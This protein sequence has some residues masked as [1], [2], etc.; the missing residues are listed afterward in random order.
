MPEQTLYTPQA[1]INTAKIKGYTPLPESLL[2]QIQTPVGLGRTSP[3]RLAELMKLPDAQGNYA[4]R[5]NPTTQSSLTQ[6]EIRAVLATATVQTHRRSR[7]QRGGLNTQ[8]QQP[9]TTSE[10][11]PPAPLAEPVPE[12]I[13]R[14]MEGLNDQERALAMHKFRNIKGQKD[15]VDNIDTMLAELKRIRRL[16]QVPVTPAPTPTTATP[17]V[18]PAAPAPP[19][20][21]QPP[22]EAPSAPPQQAIV[23]R[24]IFRVVP[25]STPRQSPGDELMD[26]D[27]SQIPRG[28]YG[29]IMFISPNLE[30]NPQ[31]RLL[32]E[33]ES[34]LY[35][36]RQP[37]EYVEEIQQ[38]SEQITD[39]V[40]E[41]LK[42]IVCIPVAGHQEGNNIYET[43][44]N[45]IN[46]DATQDEYEVL[47]FVNWPAQDKDGNPLNA[48]ATFSAI[49]K[50]RSE[51]PDFPLRVIS[52]SFAQS[53]NIG[54]FRKYLTDVALWRTQQRTNKS[55][56]VIFI[57]N[58]ADQKGVAPTYINNFIEKF[59]ETPDVDGYLGQL[60]WNPEDYVKY[61]ALHIG[62]RLFQYLN[63]IGR[64]RSGG[65]PTSGANFA[66]KGSIYAAVGG[67]Q[68]DKVTGEDI[69]LGQAI[70]GLRKDKAR[71]KFAGARNSRLFTSTRRAIKRFIDDGL[72]P[73]EQWDDK[74]G[75]FDEA[76][77]FEQSTA[78][79]INYD[80][81]A[82]ID[83]LKQEI[84]YVIDR[85]L[86]VY[87]QGDKLGKSAPFYRKA[88]GWLGIHY[89]V[90]EGKV[91]ITDMSTLLD[92]LREYKA[93]GPLLQKVKSGKATEEEIAQFHE[94]DQTLSVIPRE[95]QRQEEDV[96]RTEMTKL[97]PMLRQ[98]QL[99]DKPPVSQ[100]LLD[101]PDQE[102][103]AMTEIDGYFGRQ[104]EEYRNQLSELN[105]QI[106]EPMGGQTKIA[107]LIPV[108]G[109][110]EEKNIYHTLESFSKQTIG[111]EN[112]EVILFVNAS[113]RRLVDRAENIRNTLKEIER[114][115][116][117][118]PHLK[119]RMASAALPDS[120]VRIG[121]IRKILTDLALLRQK[122]A[123]I[124]EDLLLLSND[125]DNEGIADNY[126]ESF[127]SYFKNNPNK[128]GAVGN[129]HFDPKGFIRFPGLHLRTEFVTKLDQVGFKNGNV[130]L[131]GS[132]SVMKSSTYAAIGGYPTN[133]RSG[134]QE[135][136]GKT[137]RDLR[138]TNQTLGYVDEAL[139]T[140]SIRRGI[141]SYISS[142]EGQIAFG[143]ITKEQTMRSLD[144]SSFPVFKFTDENIATLKT[145]IEH[146]IDEII[147]AYDQG[148]KLGK[149]SWFYSKTLQEMG[150]AYEVDGDPMN[151][152]SKIRVTDITAFIRRSQKIRE[153]IESGETNM[154]DVIKIANETPTEPGKVIAAEQTPMPE[155][156]VEEFLKAIVK[157]N[158]YGKLPSGSQIDGKEIRFRGTDFHDH[159]PDSNIERLQSEMNV[160]GLI[161]EIYK[162]QIPDL[163]SSH[164]V[165]VV[166]SED[167]PGN[168]LLFIDFFQDKN[169]I[170]SRTYNT[171][172]QVGV[173]MP[174]EVMSDFLKRIVENPDLLE[175][176]Y[177][178][179]FAGLDSQEG[180][181]GMLRIKSDG[182][183]IITGDKL[184]EAEKISKQFG[185]S[186]IT[187][188]FN[189]LEKYQ[190]KHGPYGTGTALPLESQE[191]LAPAAIPVPEPLPQVK[192]EDLPYSDLQLLANRPLFDQLREGLSVDPKRQ[193]PLDEGI[194]GQFLPQVIRQVLQTPE[195][196]KY[197]DDLAPFTPTISFRDNSVT[198]EAT[199]T[200]NLTRPY[201]TLSFGKEKPIHIRGRIIMHNGVP[202]ISIESLDVEKLRALSGPF[203]SE[204]D[205]IITNTRAK[206][207]NELIVQALQSNRIPV[208]NSRLNISG[209]AATL[210]LEN[211]PV[212]NA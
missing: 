72:A 22:A 180:K 98:V 70:I 141:V 10:P 35:F 66:F 102:L 37:K 143:D 181:P 74:F 53:G 122:N 59:E 193:I 135:W 64:R 99:I 11:Q 2:A 155:A 124:S 183:F 107:V 96:V 100:R 16:P 19:V 57:S 188:F 51:H 4:Q 137:I 26:F 50:F 128:E 139:L 80:D 132:N 171:P 89:K 82:E 175:D 17:H 93:I 28:Q 196:S 191:S 163:L 32:L 23:E 76:R 176:F 104:S 140:T 209:G 159:G 86:D 123:G 172:A 205:K 5:T 131:F 120:Q 106:L 27:Q 201:A 160:L 192:F 15:S 184:K 198:F 207:A 185:T 71:L 6:E 161:D 75:V 162:N 212:S 168:M 111:P 147:R 90:E 200:L 194:I 157:K 24:E 134:E 117:D 174:A 83:K 142:E 62:T 166:P 33:E 202:R 8:E 156:T 67:Y 91:K 177:Q 178:R 150:I 146:A 182:F 154:A 126:L 144:L 169:Q 41:N 110:Q 65:I 101:N 113:A 179:A 60:D 112:Y 211:R 58:D 49:E 42:A 130:T 204:K 167:N 18:D 189:S 138:H 108:A 129:L 78:S 206:D 1:E 145:E 38:L 203:N 165:S 186:G 34:R 121:N 136:T 164:I 39:P 133:L 47:L 61:P 7:Q 79:E 208:T 170:D 73:V 151:P 55:G 69:S 116:I 190:Y 21:P 109:A 9:P 43:L 40:S 103:A 45:Y 149:D 30:K 20:Q 92:T 95:K 210:F 81:P 54:Q 97:L 118:F 85:T 115:K 56:E 152:D 3:E 127:E 63:T 46:Q 153:I 84:E 87:E 25:T 48:D 148:E 94:L 52:K 29:T 14:E 36:E 187:T 195:A 13:E 197:I 77:H 158:A 31:E 199:S 119:I 173:E 88:L 68:A 125:A 105:S 114:A 44:T 12:V